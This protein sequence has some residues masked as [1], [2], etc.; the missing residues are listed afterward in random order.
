M[1]NEW[2]RLLQILS[3]LSLTICMIYI[4]DS[5]QYYYNLFISGYICLFFVMI[6]T[7]SRF[8]IKNDNRFTV[9]FGISFGKR[10][11]KYIYIT[12]ILTYIIS[13]IFNIITI[14]LYVWY[15]I[16]YKLSPNLMLYISL[17]AIV[18]TVAKIDDIYSLFL[19]FKNTH[20]TLFMNE[21]K[22]IEKY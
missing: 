12:W 16:L 10:R 19:K 1:I 21:N 20:S 11:R 9:F 13:I 8:F 3:K 17:L 18:D 2:K 4:P 6:F 15:D 22:L 7:I 14:I 5:K